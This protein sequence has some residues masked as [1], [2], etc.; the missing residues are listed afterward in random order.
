MIAFFPGYNLA[1]SSGTDGAIRNG[2]MTRYPFIATNSWFDGAS[3]TNY[4]HNG[5]F[6]R[7]LFEVALA[8]PGFPDPLHV[9]VTHLKSGQGT[10][11]SARRAAEA[12]VISNFLPIRSLSVMQLTLM[13]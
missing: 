6:T 12:S 3:L 8:V 1:I 5:V 13:C 10:D 4:G 11:D 9:F 7:D 2:V